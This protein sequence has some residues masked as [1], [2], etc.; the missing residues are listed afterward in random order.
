MQALKFER[1]SAGTPS[2][3]THARRDG[4]GVEPVL[5]RVPHGVPARVDAWP[6]GKGQPQPPWE[7]PRAI[8]PARGTTRRAR[9]RSL[10]N[11]VVPE[12]ARVVGEYAKR[13][14]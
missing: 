11:A 10:G 2:L 4:R 9:L 1:P 3:W 14:L 6:A 12:C 7:P 13:Y 5:G 8:E